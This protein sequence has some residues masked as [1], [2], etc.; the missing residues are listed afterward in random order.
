MCKN[1]GMVYSIQGIKHETEKHVLQGHV[2]S[3]LF[4]H[5]LG[6][7]CFLKSTKPELALEMR[8]DLQDWF[9]ALKLAKS[10]SP[11]KE[12][13]IC[14]KLA[15]QVENQGNTIEAQ[16]LYEKALLTQ[17]QKEDDKV[18][19]EQHNTQCYGGI[20]RTAIK[21]GD[22]QRGYSIASNINDKNIVIDIAGVCEQMKQWQEAAKLYQKG[23]LV[24]KAASIYIQ[25]KMFS[26]AAPLMDQITSPSILIMVAKA[27]EAEN[28]YKE[29][30][31]AYERANDWENIIRL[32]LDHLN[33]AE[34]AKHI[35][36]TKSQLPQCAQQI[37]NYCETQGA[38]KEAIEFLVLAG[39]REEAFIIAQ[40]HQE[41]D[42]YATIIIKVDEKNVDEH[43]KIAQFY[44]GKSQWGKAAKHYEKSENHNKALKLY[45]SEGESKIPDMIE[46]VSKIKNDAL[47]HEL[48]DY[49]MGETD[50]IPKEPQWTFK[51]YRAIG[52]VK[53]A[54]KIA[55]NI[56]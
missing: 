53:Q 54:V 50:N 7:E 2:A 6:Q 55:I 13:L 34:K 12:Q 1:V 28:N 4:K 44:E 17:Q 46:M 30:E 41:M 11:E 36:R 20:A 22:I 26:A 39:K 21:M 14:R 35:F 24:E 32:N 52:N 18:N 33:N 8:M 38:K 47:T 49:L 10:I 40:S 19:H 37:A 15:S 16:K 31:A 27:K 9:Q 51:L 5:D 48:V 29:A 56:S 42:E 25:I 43:L 3:I 45:I 23:G